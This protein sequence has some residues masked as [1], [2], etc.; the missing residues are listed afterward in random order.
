MGTMNTYVLTNRLRTY[1]V[2][3]FKYI[4][5]TYYNVIPFLN[6]ISIFKVGQKTKTTD[7]GK[8]MWDATTPLISYQYFHNSKKTPVK[9]QFFLRTQL[10]ILHNYNYQLTERITNLIAQ[11]TC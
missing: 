1:I 11:I 6:Y 9:G 8:L 4:H 10:T 7:L 3:I 5:K 2:T